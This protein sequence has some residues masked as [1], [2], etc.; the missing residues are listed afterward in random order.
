MP[1]QKLQFKPGFN[2]D[3]TNYSNEQGW[4][5]GDKVR[6]RLGY[7]EQIGGWTRL[8]NNT[9]VGTAR[10]LISWIAL[11]GDRL[12]G[13]GT[14]LKYYVEEGGA[15]NDITPIRATS[16]SLSNVITTDTTTNTAGN[17]TV[18]TITDTHGANDGDFC[19]I[20]GAS[21]FNG[22]LA[23]NINKE[24]QLTVV[25]SN[26]FTITIDGQASS[27]GAGGGTIDIEYQITTGPSIFTFT[28]GWGSGSWPDYAEA[29]LASPFDTTSGSS[30][31][32]VNKTGHGLSTGD[33]VTFVS[34]GTP[35]AVSGGGVSAFD[36]DDIM[37]MAFPVT[38]TGPNVFT[39]SLVIG[40]TTY[41][42]DATATGVGGTVVIRS[43]ATTTSTWGTT[44]VA[45]LAQQLRLYT[46]DTF[47]EDLVFNVY[48]GGFYYWDKSAG[49]NTRAVTV[50]SLSGA[51]QAPTQVNRVLTSDQ[52]RHVI[53][54]GTNN[55]GGSGAYDP[56]L[57]R[58]SD[59]EAPEKWQPTTTNSAG[60]YRLDNGSTI[61]TA[62]STRQEI[63]I[64]TD[65][66]VYSMQYVG[67]PYVF[68]FSLLADNISIISPNA[69]ASA[70]NIVYWMGHDKFYVYDGQVRALPSTVRDFVFMNLDREQ[71]RQIFSGGNEG[72]NEIWW[73]YPKQGSTIVTNYV[74]YNYLENIWYFGNMNRTAWLDNP[75]NTYPIAALYYDTESA[76]RLLYHEFGVDD[77]SGG[78][79]VPLNSFI[80]S[81]DFLIGDG[82]QFSFIKRMIP[83]LLFA[84]S[85]LAELPNVTITLTPRD[86]TGTTYN[87]GYAKTINATALS[88]Q[89]LYTS[90]IDVRVRGRQVK[91]R[92][93]G[94][95]NQG[96]K[97]RLGTPRVEIQPDGRR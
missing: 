2:R 41:T 72:Y 76:G 51:T 80:E 65:T 19:T 68:S 17:K 75:L 23:A 57:V 34:I 22:V 69:V 63:L 64:F 48:A 54:F 43:P 47:G 85:T 38:V 37:L 7:P 12:T 89:E 86:Y 60:D 46:H 55:L 5:D 59:S 81:S 36:C 52:A 25:T 61:I 53:C 73:F 16:T 90:P 79:S 28:S 71:E 20:S 35:F 4:F 82:N 96:T 31:I 92:I 29:T 74:I 91:M 3:V 66:A 1:L 9:Y 88:P 67:Y 15:Y 78:G 45:D 40:G 93:N 70:S 33:Y 6:F 8:S 27:S 11:D 39:V 30:T 10:N 95:D 14:N 18:L 49:V 44:G 56:L 58:W 21:D 77:L 87:E 62:I 13:V 42:A 24:H 97:W 50:A 83:D 32:T 94:S 26:T 84:D